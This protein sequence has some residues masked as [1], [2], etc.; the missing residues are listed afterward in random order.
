MVTLKTAITTALAL[1]QIDY[2][3]RAGEI[4]LMVDLSGARWGAILNQLNK[5]DRRHPCRFKS[6]I[7]LKGE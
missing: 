6:G 4:I 2:S 5:E 7:W 3:P 1:I